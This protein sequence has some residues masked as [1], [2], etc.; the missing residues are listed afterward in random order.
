MNKSVLEKLEF[1]KIQQRLADLAYSAGGSRLALE[2][3]PSA[4]LQLVRQRLEQTEEAMELLRFGEPAFFEL[5]Q[6]GG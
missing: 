3:E 6:A 5:P 2:L 1:D 4:D